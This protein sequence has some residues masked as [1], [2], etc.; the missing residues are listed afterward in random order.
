MGNSIDI[1]CCKNK[2]NDK[3]MDT[4]SL[5]RGNSKP[6]PEQDNVN[7]FLQKLEFQN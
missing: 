5:E 6:Q 7:K 4:N 2:T 1:A 3:T